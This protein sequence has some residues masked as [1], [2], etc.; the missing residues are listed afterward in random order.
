MLALLSVC[1]I[2]CKLLEL[3]TQNTSAEMYIAG[4][5]FGGVELERSSDLTLEYTVKKM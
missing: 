4:P 3:Y 1:F 5:A 2:Q